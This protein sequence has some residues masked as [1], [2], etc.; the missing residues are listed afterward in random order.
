MR[1]FLR[2]PASSL[3]ALAADPN[4]VYIPPDRILTGKLDNSAAAINASVVW[5][6]GD[7]GSGIGVAVLDSGI[8]AD[9]NFGGGLVWSRLPFGV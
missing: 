6:V 7:N 5:R 3:S 9:V 2:V 8:N 4:V 1:L